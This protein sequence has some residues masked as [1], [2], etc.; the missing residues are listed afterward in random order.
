MSFDATLTATAVGSFPHRDPEVACDLV[1][2]NFPQIPVWPQ[3]PATALQEQMEIQFSEGLPCVVIDNHKERMYF[4]T[5]GDPTPELERFYENFLADNLEYFCI[6]S[7]FSRGL[8]IMAKRLSEM[9]RSGIEYIKMQ[10]TG[11]VS[12]GLSTVDEQKR[13]IYYNEMFLDVVVKNI[14]MKVRWQLNKFK[15][16]CDRLIC[17]ID[18]PILSAFGSST[19]VSVKREDVV[20]HIGEVVDSIHA[21][22]ALAGIHCCGNTEWTIAIDTGVDIINFDAWDYGETIALYADPMRIFLQNGG[23]LAWGIVPTSEKI[24]KL[25][26]TD[27]LDKFE[28]LLD[29]M[30]SKG[31]ERS[32]ILEN[33]LLTASCGTGSVPVGRAERVAEETRLVSEQLKKRYR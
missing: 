2:K 16:L 1:L 4:D 23:V 3:L 19:Y 18:E 17:F 21:E 8:H 6:S 28:T 32:L 20:A 9:D 15:P 24:E 12:F 11:P 26:T 7:D 13:A 30:E 33:A 10:V 31:V 22:G 5:T 29:M 14:S 27:L 25:N